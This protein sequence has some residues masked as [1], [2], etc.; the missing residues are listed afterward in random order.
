[1][2][3][4]NTTS[5]VIKNHPKTAVVLFN[6]GGPQTL[7]DVEPF[8]YNLFADPEIIQF[9][10][11][12]GLQKPLAWLIAK[13]R[14]RKV[15]ESYRQI[16]GGSPIRRFSEAQ[17]QAL[18]DTLAQHGVSV[19]ACVAMRYWHPLTETVIEQ[20]RQAETE[21]IIGV[22]MYPHF[23]LTTTGSSVNEFKRVLKAVGW[24]VPFL[25]LPPCYNHPSYLQAMADQIR[26]TLDSSCWGC[27]K[28]EV[29]ILFSAHSLP[30]SFVEESKDPYPEQI[31]K[32]A[33]QLAH[34]FF[35]EHPWTLSYQS[36]VGPIPWLDPSTDQMLETLAHQ[37]I[38]N[39]LVVPISFVTDHLETL[40]EID[41]EY[42]HLAQNLGIE[43]FHRTAPIMTHPSYMDCLAQGVIRTM[44]FHQRQNGVSFK[45]SE[46]ALM[47]V[48]G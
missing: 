6:L 33:E 1:M 41:I 18:Q 45:T 29:M 47:T 39:L 35:P 10:K 5:L 19:S 12:P 2:P 16:G 43:H 37:G 17:A 36:K 48:N 46:P 23:S 13:A 31:W 15:R 24:D 26:A 34:Q 20:L 4:T 11:I 38:K 8:L 7:D 44:T 22:S 14:H 42:G 32:T 21:L 40:F 25:N 28:N 27:P 9:S 3:P 30:K